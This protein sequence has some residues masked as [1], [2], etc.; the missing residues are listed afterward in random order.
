MLV[1]G[2]YKQVADI[3]HQAIG[4]DNFLE[5]DHR[6]LMRAYAK[7]GEPAQALHHYQHFNTL[8][9]DELGVESSPETTDLYLHIQQGQ[10]I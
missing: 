7:M 4:K 2:R 10:I 5:T 3:Y 8:L 9:Q 6:Q 1:N